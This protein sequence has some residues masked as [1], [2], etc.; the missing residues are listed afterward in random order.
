[1]VC[2]VIAG[3][4]AQGDPYTHFE[5]FSYCTIQCL[6]MEIADFDAQSGILDGQLSVAVHHVKARYQF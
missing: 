2:F 4:I 5:F 1:M 3:A 6:E